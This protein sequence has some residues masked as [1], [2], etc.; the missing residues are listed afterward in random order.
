MTYLVNISKIVC[1]SVALEL[2]GVKHK[3]YFTVGSSLVIAGLVESDVKKPSS[4]V[5]LLMPADS[6]V[7]RGKNS[8]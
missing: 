1:S 6:L 2:F 3:Q 5:Y 4:P 8:W 7:E